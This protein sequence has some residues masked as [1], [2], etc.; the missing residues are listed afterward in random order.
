MAANFRKK[1]IGVGVRL[2]GSLIVFSQITLGS[3]SR[4]AFCL[5]AEREHVIEQSMSTFGL[6]E[7]RLCSGLTH[8]TLGGLVTVRGQPHDLDVWQRLVNL[9]RRLDAVF[10]RHRN[11]HK[12]DVWLQGLG[13][14]DCLDAV[15]RL[16]HNPKL[17]P[18]AEQF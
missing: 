14:S 1:E 6:A 18:F 15:G 9:L 10:L 3:I 7:V 4:S 17:G 11:V 8:R 5:W 12:N 16:T 2:D 13:V